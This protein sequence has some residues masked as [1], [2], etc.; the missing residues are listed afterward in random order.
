M[1]TGPPPEVC[2]SAKDENRSLVSSGGLTCVPAGKHSNHEQLCVVYCI[3]CAFNFIKP[4]FV[5]FFWGGV[6]FKVRTSRMKAYY[7]NVEYLV[8]N[9]ELFI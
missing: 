5:F 2:C 4:S 1:T 6:Y 7:V 3:I 8:L 9:H